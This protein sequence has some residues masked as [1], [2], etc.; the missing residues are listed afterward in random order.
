M[1]LSIRM[2]FVYFAFLSSALA[3]ST[4]LCM[5]NTRF[6]TDQCYHDIDNI[7][8]SYE[9]STG[10]ILKL[11]AA[12]NTIDRTHFIC[13]VWMI[14]INTTITMAVLLIIIVRHANSKIPPRKVK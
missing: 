9:T 6:I 12:Q 11:L 14:L 1:Y 7:N 4:L 2:A 3:I 10:P 5:L 8:T 13:L